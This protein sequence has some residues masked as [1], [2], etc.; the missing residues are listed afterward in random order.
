MHQDRTSQDNSPTF[1]AYVPGRFQ[2]LIW[3]SF[4]ASLYRSAVFYAERYFSLDRSNHDARHLYATSLLRCE[5]VHSALHLVNSSAEKQCL[6]CAMIKAECY[7]ALGRHNQAGEILE[8]SVLDP[9]Y[10]ALDM[11]L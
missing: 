11:S 2:T 1:A 10:S 8:K 4:D 5:Q 9:A 3:S 7:T 6:D